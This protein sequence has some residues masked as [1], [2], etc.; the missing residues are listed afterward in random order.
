MKGDRIVIRHDLWIELLKVLYVGH[1]GVAKTLR[2][3]REIVSWPGLTKDITDLTGNWDSNSNSKEPLQT[4][5]VYSYSWQ[6]LPFS[7]F[8][9]TMTVFCLLTIIHV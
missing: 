4:H 5:E 8:W 7:S 6:K 9:V 1:T 3:A 2:R